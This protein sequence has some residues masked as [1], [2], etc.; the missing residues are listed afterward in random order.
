M[1]KLITKHLATFLIIIAIS[2]SNTLF[3]KAEI[4]FDQ[5]EKFM[6]FRSRDVL[7][8][9][10]RDRLTTDLSSNIE[11]LAERILPA[12]HS[13]K[14]TF[15]DIDMAGNILPGANEIR[16]V[17]NNTDRTLLKFNYEIIDDN[18]ELIKKGQEKLVNMYFNNAM[19]REAK[20]FRKTRFAHEMVLLARWLKKQ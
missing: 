13:L 2:A 3:A 7:T 11:K 18:G 10:D 6:D 12:N 4:S 16:K 15:T 9:I 20:Q 17:L 5:P 19:N 1:K 14:I 8:T